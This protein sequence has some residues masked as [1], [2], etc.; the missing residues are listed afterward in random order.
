[1]SIEST[2]NAFWPKAAEATS[3][4]NLPGCPTQDFRVT[5]VGF[6][7]KALPEAANSLILRRAGRENSVFAPKRS[8]SLHP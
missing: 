5:N 1:V 4:F 8:H 3:A 7:A 2:T 6:A